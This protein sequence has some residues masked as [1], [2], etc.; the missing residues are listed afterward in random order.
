MTALILFVLGI[1][2]LVFFVFFAI[3]SSKF[4]LYLVKGFTAQKI[5]FNGTFSANMAVLVI[6]LVLNLLALYLIQN[7]WEP[8]EYQPHLW[9]LYITNV[10][11]YLFA[12]FVVTA[13][14]VKAAL[15]RILLIAVVKSLG[16]VLIFVGG[17]YLIALLGGLA[18]STAG[19]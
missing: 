10:I 13:I 4:H 19:S 1:L 14:K 18:A 7:L 16:D 8:V 15:T 2:V 3:F 9:I 11:G 6:F 17:L 5:P 12:N